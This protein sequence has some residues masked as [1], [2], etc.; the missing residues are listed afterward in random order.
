MTKNL[1]KETNKKRKREK[2]MKYLKKGIACK[3][4]FCHN[5]CCCFNI[6]VTKISQCDMTFFIVIKH[7]YFLT[8]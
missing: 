1:K 4:Q 7:T 5:E 8:F 6:A 2:N 3:K